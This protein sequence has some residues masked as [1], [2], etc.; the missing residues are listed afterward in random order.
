VAGWVLGMHQ[1]RARSGVN[2]NGSLCAGSAPVM[3]FPCSPCHRPRVKCSPLRLNIR[4]ETTF[5]GPGEKTETLFFPREG[6]EGGGGGG[7]GAGGL[8][9]VVAFFFFCTRY[10]D[11]RLSLRRPDEE[12]FSI[13]A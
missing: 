10:D 6:K 11:R 9:I 12:D 7:E 4:L 1:A 2:V 13:F 8:F 5:S 3:A